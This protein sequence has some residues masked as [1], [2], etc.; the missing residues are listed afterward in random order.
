[1]SKSWASGCVFGYNMLKL[2]YFRAV[3]APKGSLLL[4]GGS[5]FL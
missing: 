1:M 3:G 5:L 2:T 4:V